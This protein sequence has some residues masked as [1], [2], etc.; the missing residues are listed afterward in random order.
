MISSIPNHLGEAVY[1]GS[2]DQILD[3]GLMVS[4]T[5]TPR[6]ATRASDSYDTNGHFSE[7]RYRE[8]RGDLTRWNKTPVRMLLSEWEKISYNKSVEEVLE[9]VHPHNVS[10]DRSNISTLDISTLD[11]PNTPTSAIQDLINTYTRIVDVY[12]S[13]IRNLQ[14]LLQPQDS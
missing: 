4:T 1:T 12:T 14:A 5:P 13:V 10:S 2:G 9:A 3:I 11:T 6:V 8:Y 7:Y